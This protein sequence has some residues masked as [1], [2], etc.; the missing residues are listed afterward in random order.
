MLFLFLC[1]GVTCDLLFILQHVHT[2]FKANK[3]GKLIN[4]NPLSV[5]PFLLYLNCSHS[6]SAQ[7]NVSLKNSS[8]AYFRR[9]LLFLA[10]FSSPSINLLSLLYNYIYIFEFHTLVRTLFSSS[11]SFLFM[12]PAPSTPCHPT[13]TCPHTYYAQ[14]LPHIQPELSTITCQTSSFAYE[15]YTNNCDRI[16]LHT[17]CITTSDTITCIYVLGC[18]V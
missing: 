8:L 1:I 13:S 4:N 3:I 7:A 18:M 12:S 6:Y 15:V 9:F 14:P 10:L 16:V 11:S 5:S 2:C 17:I